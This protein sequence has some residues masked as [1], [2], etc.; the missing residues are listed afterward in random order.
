MLFLFISVD[1][2]LI[3]KA[4]SFKVGVIVLGIAFTEWLEVCI[5]EYLL[6]I[7]SLTPVLELLADGVID[8]VVV[9]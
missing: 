1:A 7:D 6:D 5:S 2:V 9:T 4:D 3:P 8:G